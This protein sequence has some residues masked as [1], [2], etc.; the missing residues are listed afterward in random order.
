MGSRSVVAG[1]GWPEQGR[2]FGPGW[3]REFAGGGGC[4]ERL[5]LNCDGGV[6]RLR[7]ECH[8]CLDAWMLGCFDARRKVDLRRERLSQEMK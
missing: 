3:N 7:K 8:G 2:T 5:E 6:R 1:Q 4:E